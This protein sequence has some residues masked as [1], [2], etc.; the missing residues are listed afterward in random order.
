MEPLGIDLKNSLKRSGG[1]G[2]DS[3]KG[4]NGND[5]LLGEGGKDKVWGGKGND[6]LLGGGGSDKLKGGDGNDEISGGGG[7]DKIWGDR[8][9]DTLTG[10]GSKDVFVVKAKSGLDTITDLSIKQDRIDLKG[11]LK[12][13]DLSFTQRQDDVLVK[14]NG[15]NLLL[16]E[17]VDIADLT[18]K[19][20]I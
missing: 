20:F 2:A 5:R 12:F 3:V 15:Q 4:G 14:A 6:N 11:K 7:K 10:G 17:G 9:K 16:I 8:G 19:V 18:P 13:G 1:G